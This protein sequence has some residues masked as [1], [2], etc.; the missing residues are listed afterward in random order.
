MHYGTTSIFVNRFCFGKKCDNQETTH[1]NR[2]ISATTL[3]FPLRD[4]RKR[5]P[6]RVPFLRHLSDKQMASGVLPLRFA[7]AMRGV[8][9][10]SCINKKVETCL[11]WLLSVPG[12]GQTQVQLQPRAN[13]QKKK[14]TQ[15][16]SKPFGRHQLLRR[17][18]L[19][20]HKRI[21]TAVL[22]FT[23]SKFY[24]YYF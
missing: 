4:V 1:N 14:R 18:N 22:S 3:T 15:K 17:H 12:G 24:D 21:C 8:D 16:S 19:F 23:Q 5:T 7:E 20:P 10:T 13:N 9:M 11:C 6:R 2:L